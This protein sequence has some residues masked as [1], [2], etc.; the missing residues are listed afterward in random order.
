MEY[1]L[2]HPDIVWELLL[3]HGQMTGTGLLISL[4]VALPIGVL[5]HHVGWLYIPVMGTLGMLYTIPSLALIILLVPIFGL[6][7]TSVIIALTIY[8][9]VILVRNVVAGLG[10][11]DRS[12]IE[13]ARGMGMSRWKIWWRIQMPLALPIILAGLR[14]AAIVSIGIAAI[15]AKFGAGGLGKLLFDG[16]AQNNDHKIWAGALVLAAMA[17]VANGVLQ[18]LE[19]LFNPKTKIQRAERRHQQQIARQAAAR[20]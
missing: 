20:G 1:I 12:V 5:I 10:S 2:E 16:I 6:D 17:M 19:W 15:G 3:K 7:E 9:Q 14:I 4:L 13:A 8:A 11:I 18:A